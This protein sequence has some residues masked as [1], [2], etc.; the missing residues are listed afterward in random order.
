MIPRY[1]PTYDQIDLLTSLLNC[2]YPKVVEDLRVSLK[3]AYGVKFV[4]LCNSARSALSALLSALKYKGDALLPAY[5][6]IVVPEAVYFSGLRPIFADI[7]YWTLN[8][9]LETFARA[10]TPDTRVVLATHT[11]GIPCELGAIVP[12]FKDKGIFVVEDA[13]PALGAKYENRLVGTFG[14]AAIVSFELTK[15]ISGGRGGAVL[16]NNEEV[17]S[18]LQALVPRKT[19]LSESFRAYMKNVTWR[20]GNNPQIYPLLLAIFRILNGETT[21]EIVL[22]AQKMPE[23][24]LSEISSFVAA[25]VSKQLSRLEEN[26]RIRSRIARIYQMELGETEGIVLPI[27]PEESSPSWIQFPILVQEKARWYKNMQRR[28]VDL[29]W[30]YKYSC[31]ES[32]GVLGYANAD[33]AART[34]LGLPTYPG[35]SEDEARRICTLCKNL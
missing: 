11:F 14:D 12:Y 30:T 9:T 21:H 32:Y 10:L 33:L 13:A 24:Y 1:A 6:C 34:V 28:G 18:R 2:V 29:S 8:A 26:I 19:T 7:D 20:I 15:V 17:G 16:T 4:F 27:I 25:L 22:P 23:K 31:A 5:T 3:N 35:L